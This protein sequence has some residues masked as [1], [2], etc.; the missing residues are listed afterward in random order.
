MKSLEVIVPGTPEV[1]HGRPGCTASAGVVSAFARPE[2]QVLWQAITNLEPNA[3]LRWDDDHGDEG[4][5]ILDGAALVEGRD[6]EAGDAMVVGA[7]SPASI[8]ARRPTRLLQV[9]SAE[10]PGAGSPER[11]ASHDHGVHVIRASEAEAS[12]PATGP[13]KLAFFTDGTCAGCSLALF[14]VDGRAATD[15]FVST[16]HFHSEDELIHV[17]DGEL[18]IGR[19]VVRAGMSVIIPA[20][21]RY[22]FRTPGPFRFLNY[23]SDV[24][25]V[26]IG[27]HG[28][29]KAETVETMRSRGPAA[30]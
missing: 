16:S 7:G 9:G 2:G 13:V 22:G 30:S 18:R 1:W 10:G 28:E 24:S 27:A 3:E 19:D 4:V 15:G 12:G 20:D 23:R 5:F 6:C 11:R 21:W 26:T 17:L 8:R 14:V 29:P 25:L